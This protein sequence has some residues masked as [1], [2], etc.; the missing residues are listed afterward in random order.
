[1]GYIPNLVAQSLKQQQTNSVGLVVTSIADPFVGR[2][3]RGIDE[4]AQNAQMSVF[5]S[6]SKNDP[7]REI[8]V[9]EIF[10][11]RRVDGIIVAASRI[12]SQYAS[13]LAQIKIPTVLINQ[14][15]EVQ[16]ESLHTIAIDDFGGARLAVEHLLSLGHR[17]IGYIG[18]GNRP[19]SNRL[20]RQ[21]YLAALSEA[22]IQPCEEWIKIAPPERRF[23]SDDVTD[24]EM[25]LPQLI[26]AGVTAVFCYNDMIALGALV[27]SRALGQTVP[28]QLS[29]VGFDDIEMAQYVTPPL[30]TVHQPKLRLGRMAMEMLLGLLSDRPVEDQVLSTELI[31]RGSTARAS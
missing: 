12:S 10:H 7:E 30:T 9:I 3:V 1:M 18:A 6:V 29:L 21:G 4:V 17:S 22:G 16:S 26:Q 24:G 13:R 15:A 19:R 27:A 11:R 28:G 20:R 14:Q 5:L 31:V 2:V 23:H 25:L 8:S